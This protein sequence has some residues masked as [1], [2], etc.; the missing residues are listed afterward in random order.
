MRGT[1]GISEGIRQGSRLDERSV[2]VYGWLFAAINLLSL[3]VLLATSRGGIDA[4]GH[5][6]GSDFLSF[7]AAGKLLVAG[8]SPYDTAAHLAVMRDFAPGLE[9]YPAFYYPPL[10]LLACF[11]LGGLPYFPALGLWLIVTGA[12]YLGAVRLWLKE[13]GLKIPL[14]LWLAAFPP[15]VVTITHGQTSFLVAALLGAGLLLIKDRPWLGGLLLGLATFK[16]QFGLLIP[17]AVLL[18]GNWRVGVAAV[19][20]MSVLITIVTVAFGP[21]NWERWYAL[22]GDAQGSMASGAIGYGKM[23][24]V[25]AGAKLLGAGDTLAYALQGVVS[26]TVAVAV[27]MVSW[28]RTWSN[29]L[30]A[31]VL[32]GALLATPFVLDYDLL[33]LAFPLIYLAATG[34]RDWEKS[35]SAAVFLGAILAR[36]VALNLGVPIMPVLVGLLFWVLW[37]RAKEEQS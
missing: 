12:A 33:L 2:R 19:F 6:I 23:M 8:G 17:I 37:R 34:Y 36:P 22:T 31:L 7:W 27:A 16:P 15:V 20:S 10:F 14:W 11:A 18:T 30:A 5:L 1:M 9:G 13:T 3:V 25:F 35:I 28:K 24:S 29:G 26:V 21:E 4:Y 32:A